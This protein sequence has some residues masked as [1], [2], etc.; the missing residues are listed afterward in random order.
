MT[1][2][3]IAH[4]N[5]HGFW[6]VFFEELPGRDPVPRTLY[7]PL[8]LPWRP[9]FHLFRMSNGPSPGAFVAVAG[10]IQRYRAALADEI[11]QLEHRLQLDRLEAKYERIHQAQAV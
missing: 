5:P 3:H 2:S 6:G 11:E 10:L 7:R 9:G 1:F 8:A 4:T